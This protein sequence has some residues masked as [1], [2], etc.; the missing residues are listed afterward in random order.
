ML[1]L[2]RGFI[3]KLRPLLDLRGIVNAKMKTLGNNDDLIK[4]RDAI[5]ENIKLM[6]NL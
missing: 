5:N 2:S 4:L 3:E 6:L 1:Q